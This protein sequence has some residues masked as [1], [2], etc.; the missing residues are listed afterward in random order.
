[1]HVVATV[2]SVDYDNAPE[3]CGMLGAS[4]SLGISDIPW[5]GRIAGVRVGKVNGAY[6]INP[7]QEQME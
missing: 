4:V 1:M 6:V 5:D 2:L 7:T 3:P